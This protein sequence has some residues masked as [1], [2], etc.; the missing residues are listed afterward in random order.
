MILLLN[1]V[2][3]KYVQENYKAVLGLYYIQAIVWLV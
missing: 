3:K 1:F 2:Y